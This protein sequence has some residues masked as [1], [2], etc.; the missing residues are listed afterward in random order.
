[1]EI[2]SPPAI[3]ET[4]AVPYHDIPLKVLKNVSAVSGYSSALA[5]AYTSRHHGHVPIARN[6]LQGGQIVIIFINFPPPLLPAFIGGL[7]FVLIT[8]L[9]FFAH[10]FSVPRSA[11]I[12]NTLP[13]PG[14][15]IMCVYIG[16]ITCVDAEVWINTRKHFGRAHTVHEYIINGYRGIGNI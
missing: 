14:V 7:Y 11:K 13:Q 15:F 9:F 2:I 1:M 5:S 8:F 6:C 3:S 12:L 4:S 10:F 16:T